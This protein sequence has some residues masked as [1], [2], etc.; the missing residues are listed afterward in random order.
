M[1]NA[2]SDYLQLPPF[3]MPAA[4]AGAGTCDGDGALLRVTSSGRRPPPGGL[5]TPLHLRPQRRELLLDG[6]RRTGEGGPEPEPESEPGAGPARRHTPLARHHTLP[7]QGAGS[8]AAA[9]SLA[10]WGGGLE[11]TTTTPQS[12]TYITNPNMPAAR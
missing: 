8:L 5:D 7:R 11:R 12:P 3:M 2:V 6:T 1:Q 10:P 4:D 9:V